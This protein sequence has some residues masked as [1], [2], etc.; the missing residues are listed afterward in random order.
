MTFYVLQELSDLLFEL[1][2]E[3]EL[4]LDDLHFFLY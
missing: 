4:T 3:G 2:E 1:L